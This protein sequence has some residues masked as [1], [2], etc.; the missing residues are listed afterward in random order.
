MIGPF[1]FFD[2]MGSV[3]LIAGQGIDVRPHPNIGLATTP[4]FF[5]GRGMH[6]DSEVNASHRSFRR[7][8]LFRILSCRP[9][10]TG[11]PKQTHLDPRR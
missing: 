6:R 10:T 8:S 2:Q 11:R 5:A 4:I 7:S 9:I 1:I 3:Q